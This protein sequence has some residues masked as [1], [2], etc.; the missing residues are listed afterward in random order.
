M[1]V[2]SLLT[3]SCGRYLRC[4]LLT[5]ATFVV[6]GDG[7]NE[8]L[9][10]YAKNRKPTWWPGPA[11]VTECS[12]VLIIVGFG[13]YVSS[14]LVP[15][16][17]LLDTCSNPFTVHYTAQLIPLH[18]VAE[19]VSTLTLCNV[20]CWCRKRSLTSRRCS[21]CSDASASHCSDNESA[22]L[23]VDNMCG[24]T[25]RHAGMLC[26]FYF[27]SFPWWQYIAGRI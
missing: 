2:L 6:V 18:I 25:S 5:Y 17:N 24:V 12:R 19:W 8:V 16:W 13:W 1:F 21:V 10:V 7:Q 23:R 15:Q 9:V 14:C 3:G 27:I 11:C 22:F 26:M 4:L 20:N